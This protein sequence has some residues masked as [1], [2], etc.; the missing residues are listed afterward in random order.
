M[1]SVF[2]LMITAFIRHQQWCSS[3]GQANSASYGSRKLPIILFLGVEPHEI[4]PFPVSMYFTAEFLA[5]L[6]STIFPPPLLQFSLSQ[7]C[8]SCGVYMHPIGLSFIQV[9]NLCIVSTSGFL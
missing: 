2:L 3:F 9:I 4:F 6:L 8:R 7:R 1:L 5:L